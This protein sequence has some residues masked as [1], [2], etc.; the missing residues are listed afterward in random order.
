M[1]DNI[2]PDPENKNLVVVEKK[3]QRFDQAERWAYCYRNCKFFGSSIDVVLGFGTTFMPAD[4]DKSKGH[5]GSKSRL[6]RL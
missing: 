2:G 6:M 4:S 3:F 5:C 1:G